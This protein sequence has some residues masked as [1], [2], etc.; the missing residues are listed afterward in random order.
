MARRRAQPVSSKGSENKKK[1]SSNRILALAPAPVIRYT[2]GPGVDDLGTNIS[3]G[4]DGIP[5]G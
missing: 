5:F 2:A 4:E 1:D 3:Y